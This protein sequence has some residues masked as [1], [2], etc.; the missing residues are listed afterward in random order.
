MCQGLLHSQSPVPEAQRGQPRR[1]ASSSARPLRWPANCARGKLGPPG[2]SVRRPPGH[3]RR[4]TSRWL[5]PGS[6]HYQQS[7]RHACALK[8]ADEEQ[9]GRAIRASALYNLPIQGRGLTAL[10]ATK[11]R[12]AGKPSA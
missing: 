9:P 7:D 8:T 2:P 10:G 1:R 6:L 4:S 3:P 12:C 11:T 5:R